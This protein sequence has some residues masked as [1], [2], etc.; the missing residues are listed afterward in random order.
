MN[1]TIFPAQVQ[2]I[3]GVIVLNAASVHTVATQRENKNVT[4]DIVREDERQAVTTASF[5]NNSATEKWTM[6]DTKLFYKYL[7]QY[8]TDFS[9]IAQ[10][11]P[12]R[13]RKQIKAKF[14]KEDKQHEDLVNL[15]LKTVMP[16][17][18]DE[19]AENRQAKIEHL[20]KE[21]AEEEKKNG[22]SSS[23]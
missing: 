4:Y 3:D 10:F 19:F 17:D 15:A 5:R 11:F 21:K 6:E 23:Q 22:G 1:P 20:A 9:L 8:G 13:S 16:M 14:K 2:I 18:V 12:T 7:S